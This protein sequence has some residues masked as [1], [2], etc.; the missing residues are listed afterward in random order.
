MGHLEK[1][2]ETDIIYENNALQ[3]VG[4]SQHHSGYHKYTHLKEHQA[5]TSVR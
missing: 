1:R 4:L 5:N 2:R 3:R